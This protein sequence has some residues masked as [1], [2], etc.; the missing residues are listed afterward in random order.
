MVI[1]DPWKHSAQI[2]QKQDGYNTYAIKK[3]MFPPSYLH[4]GFVGN[5]CTWAH[6]VRLPCT[7][8]DVVHAHVQYIMHLSAWAT[9]KLLWWKLGGHIILWL[10]IYICI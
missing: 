7:Q 9:T 4:N 8:V 3:T 5:S 10:H 6:D 2:S 1:S